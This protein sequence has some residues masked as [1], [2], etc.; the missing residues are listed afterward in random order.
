MNWF[1]NLKTRNKLYLGF[2]V[3]IGLLIII[4]GTGLINLDNI[5]H[6]INIMY[7]DGIG[8]IALLQTIEENFIR[9]GAEMRIILWKSQVKNDPSVM[10]KSIGLIEEYVRENNE[11]IEKYKTYDLSE[12]E[13]N[14]LAAYEE[15]IVI[16]RDIRN[17]SIEAAKAGDYELAG[18]YN[19]VAI[20]EREKTE[21]ILTQ[22]ADHARLYSDMLLESSGKDYSKARL[23]IILI[24]AVSIALGIMLSI[25]IGNIISRP[26]HAT[27]QHAR[28][29]AK[30]DFSSDIDD[31]LLARKD[32]IG[33]LAGAFNDISKNLRGLLKQLLNTAEEMSTS[34]EELSASTREVTAQGQNISS[35]AQQ[36]VAG[37]EETS[38]STE[39]V[40]ASGQ[41]IE[42]GAV[43]LAEEAGEGNGIVKEI[44]KRAEDMR[45][46]S[47]NSKSLTQ[48]MYQQK[49]AG[50]LKAIQEG[51]VVNEI[52][53]MAK[54][55]SDIANQ[56]NLLALNAA[57]EAARV[58]EQGRGFA[59]VSEEVRKLAEQSAQAVTGIESVIIK[60]QNAF[61]NL[62]E[63]SSEVLKFIDE[64]V[65]ADYELFVKTGVQ[66]AED[67]ETIGK[68]VEIFASTA[69]QMSASIEQVNR[70]IETVSAS[71]QEAAGSSQVI[72]INITTTAQS[73]DQV[74]KVAQTQAQLA[75]ELN[76][77]VGKFRV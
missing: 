77:M 46:T 2:A 11:L 53:V 14:L 12:E 13:K 8:I 19:A 26:I 56:T 16:Y 59:V 6:N 41:E 61:Q 55:I 34:S 63:N 62:S 37:M 32:E 45:V 4:G 20:I 74:A 42:K 76:V 17:K 18:E 3:I 44:E 60:V 47:E 21:K 49:Q 40:M 31:K 5:N 38:A 22:M 58:G 65:A 67:A 70:A 9:T 39:E 51:E 75:Q 25:I 10:D 29:L 27:V 64:K 54:T 66:Y 71:V 23:V 35:A 72:A 24:T 15:Q 52:G 33:I 68:L 50:I 69:Q 30:G 36:I 28:L 1:I 57:I 48:E 73:M 7:Q 43:Q